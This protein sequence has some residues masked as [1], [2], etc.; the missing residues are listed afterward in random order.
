MEAFEAAL[1]SGVPGVS[2]APVSGNNKAMT[3]VLPE[4][5]VL[6]KRLTDE[7][8][9]NAGAGARRPSRA[10]QA[11]TNLKRGTIVLDTCEAKAEKE[12]KVSR[13]LPFRFEL[14]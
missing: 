9:N 1:G 5:R 4:A 3:P 14:F 6:L 7:E 12:R 13:F 11:E 2:G 10:A 8:L